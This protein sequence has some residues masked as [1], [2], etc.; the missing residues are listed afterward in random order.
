MN[1]MFSTFCIGE[2]TLEQIS[3]LPPDTQLKFFWA[4]SNYGLNGIEPDFTGLELAVWIPMRDLVRSSKK[5]D[6]VW[7][8]K[9]R[10]A[11]TKG[12]APAGNANASKQAETSKN[13]QKQPETTKTSKTSYQEI[14][15]NE[16]E[17]PKEIQ[18]KH[19]H[20]ADPRDMA[21]GENPEKTAPPGQDGVCALCFFTGEG[22]S[23]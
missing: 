4:L 13:N 20:T 12:G 3:I 5:N 15:K 23:A 16:R 21:D 2:T 18:E 14:E 11:G 1:G 6:E 19:T 8:E 22:K 9:K 7:K 17:R 10:A